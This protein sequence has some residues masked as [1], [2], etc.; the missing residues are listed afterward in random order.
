M[1][2]G[3]RDGFLRPYSLFC[4]PQT[5]NFLPSSSSILLT[6]LSGPR[7]DNS[8]LDREKSSMY[9]SGTERIWMTSNRVHGGNLQRCKERSGSL[10]PG[11]V[12]TSAETHWNWYGRGMRPASDI[13]RAPVGALSRGISKTVNL[14]HSLMMCK[15]YLGWRQHKRS[16]VVQAA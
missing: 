6:T 10:G 9:G 8:K 7:E 14:K 2:R 5:L 16:S 4:R 3:Q 13:L 11:H 1:S 15:K 12:L